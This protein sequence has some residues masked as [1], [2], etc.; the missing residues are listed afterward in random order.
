MGETM[1]SR[2]NG[3]TYALVTSAYNEER[4]IEQTILSVAKQ[5]V[6]PK[7]WII[8]S[9]GSTDRT[10]DIV[11]T[12]A[13]RW[14]FIELYRITDKHPRNFGAQVNAINSGIARL[15]TVDCEFVGNL[16][17]DV[18]LQP[19]YFESV[20]RG[21]SSNP[22]LGLAGGFIYEEEH[23][24]FRSRRGNTTKSVAHAV[25]LFRREALKT[26]GGY[27]VFPGGGTDWHAQVFLRM[28]GWDV[29][30]FPNLPVFH[31]RK[32][33]GAFG[34]VRYCFGAGKEDYY[35]GTHFVIELFR[36]A[37]RLFLEKPYVLAA[38][39]RLAGFTAAHLRGEVRQVPEDFVQFLREEQKQTLLAKLHLPTI[40]RSAITA[41]ENY[42][43]RV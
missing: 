36:V 37:R 38:M 34:F 14:N 7:K 10:D 25:Q 3:W 2:E 23:G 9:D 29:K 4:Y 31:H 15:E 5:T 26:L 11:R 1:V 43:K 8:V 6:T 19:G 30:A 12:Y 20:L 39:A 16:D 28:K 21:F 13:E 41:R 24:E 42:A 32:T 27:K 40:L 33:G 17:A 22:T 35:M 18:T